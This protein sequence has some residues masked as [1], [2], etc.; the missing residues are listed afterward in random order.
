MSDM[1][2]FS[3]SDS[4]SLELEEGKD[5]AEGQGPVLGKYQPQGLPNLVRASQSFLHPQGWLWGWNWGLL[6]MSPQSCRGLRTA[7]LRAVVKVVSGT[8]GCRS[9]PGRT[10]R[11]PTHPQAPPMLSTRVQGEKFLILNNLQVII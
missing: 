2:L 7:Q 3:H 11:H 6:K 9:G 5:P 1:L 4:F 10:S 8:W